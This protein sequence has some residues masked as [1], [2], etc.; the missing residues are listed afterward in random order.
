[1]RKKI[2]KQGFTLIEILLAMMIFAMLS[3]G[4][5]QV[6]DGVMRNNK[7]NEK[8]LNRL[9]QI[10]RGML[11]LEDDFRQ[12]THRIGRAGSGESYAFQAKMG[13]AGSDDMG[14]TFIRSGWDNP[15]ARLPRSE[16]TRVA[17]RLVDNKLERVFYLY[18][19]PV[20]N[21]QEQVFPVFDEVE[22]FKLRFYSQGAWLS[23]WTRKELP[24]G[25]EIILKL[26]D[27]GEIR[28]IFTIMGN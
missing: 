22:S 18:P 24:Q 3:L 6:L 11:V 28:R 5:Y 25:I 1:M 12:I 16:L 15:N 8:V 14:V 27:F 9:G 13:Y 23:S 21:A 26:T 7:Q 19:D 2:S 10:Q 17:Y 4:A 20:I